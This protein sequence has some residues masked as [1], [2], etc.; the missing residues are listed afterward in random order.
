MSF[1]VGF[2][3]GGGAGEGK[4]QEREA[5]FIVGVRRIIPGMPIAEFAEMTR[6][7]HSLISML[8]STP[9]RVQVELLPPAETCMELI[10]ISA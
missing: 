1:D 8:Q 6:C 7:H 2:H 9:S 4:K 5:V 3:S 10:N